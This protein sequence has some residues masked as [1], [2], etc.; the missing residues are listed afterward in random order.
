[1]TLILNNDE[2]QQALSV[3]DCLE[4]MEEA[5]REQAVSQAVNRPTSHSYLPH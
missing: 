3:H 4:A 2:I 5:Y 1:M